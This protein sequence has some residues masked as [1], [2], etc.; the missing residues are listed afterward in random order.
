VEAVLDAPVMADGVGGEGC[1]RLEVGDI[2]GSFAGVFPKAC[3]GAAFQAVSLH[4]DD[5]LD[6]TVPVAGGQ[7]IAHREDLGETFFVA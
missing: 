6:E 3:F 4:A 5:A 7:G 2:V 1:R